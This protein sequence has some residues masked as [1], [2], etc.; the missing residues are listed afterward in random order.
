MKSD[1]E[2]RGRMIYQFLG[3]SEWTSC[4][5]KNGRGMPRPYMELACEKFFAPTHGRADRSAFIPAYTRRDMPAFIC[6][7]LRILL[8]TCQPASQAPTHSPAT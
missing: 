3:G 8:A 5:L 2:S 4:I 7:H 1:G 6:V